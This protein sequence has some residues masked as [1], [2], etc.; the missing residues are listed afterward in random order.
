MPA[1]A[2]RR[3]LREYLARRN[4]DC[5]QD[6]N[7]M[8]EKIFSDAFLSRLTL[9]VR[10][11]EQEGQDAND[12]EPLH[13]EDYEAIYFAYQEA[14]GD[15]TAAKQRIAAARACRDQ[16]LGQI[17]QFIADQYGVGPV[18]RLGD[19]ALTDIAR[20]AFDATEC[21]LDQVEMLDRTTV[22]ESP[23]RILLKSHYRLSEAMLHLHDTL[24]WPIAKRISPW[25]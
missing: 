11:V 21:W 23:L 7:A 20:D 15:P 2:N 19:E 18:E 17:V 1:A 6:I 3:P 16:A 4:R 14:G 24:L 9:A 22:P 8:T 5:R 25:K 12:P 10:A 13:A